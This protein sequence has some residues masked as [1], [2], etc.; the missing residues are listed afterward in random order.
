VFVSAGCGK[1]AQPTASLPPP[2]PP[3]AV[4]P[5]PPVR[6]A[7]PGRRQGQQLAAWKPVPKQFERAPG[8]PN[9]VALTFDAGSDAAAVYS[10]LKTLKAHDARAT[11][12]LTGAFCQQFPKEAKAIADAGM[13]LGNHSQT[14]PR[15]TRL[16]EKQIQQQLEASE[17]AI[18]KVCGRGGKPLFRFPYGD[19]DKRTRQAVANA[20][21]QPIYWTLDSLDSVGKPKSAEFIAKRINGKIQ[22]GYIT[23]MHV[24]SVGSAEA[25]PQIFAHLEERG[26]KVVPVSELL[27]SAPPPKPDIKIT[28]K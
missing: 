10:I 6:E 2:T 8:T 5:P 15:F 22:G 14:H 7:D 20:G 25:L 27:L 24:S 23:L 26:L 16:S 1:R 3:S 12:F 28:R 9:L 21:F 19:S 4:T 18:Q 11:F 17:A 13:E